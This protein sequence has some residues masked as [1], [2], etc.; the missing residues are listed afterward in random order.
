M[1]LNVN[2][3]QSELFDSLSFSFFSLFY[4]SQPLC[5]FCCKFSCNCLSLLCI[6][7]CLEFSEIKSILISGI[8]L[9]LPK[10][11]LFYLNNHS[12]RIAVA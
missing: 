5:L 2:F 4:E 9:S 12:L 1:L 6:Q 11:E 3:V 8:I 10:I 7:I